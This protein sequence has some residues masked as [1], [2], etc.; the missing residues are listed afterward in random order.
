MS[1]SLDNNVLANLVSTDAAHACLMAAVQQGEQASALA[2]LVDKRGVPR[3]ACSCP[4]RACPLQTLAGL[5]RRAVAAYLQSRDDYQ[6][7]NRT[8]RH[9]PTPTLQ[10]LT[11]PKA[12][13][14]P[15]DAVSVLHVTAP[16]LGCSTLA[17]AA[18]SVEVPVGAVGAYAR[19][20]LY[21][22]FQPAPASCSR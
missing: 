7:A 2:E 3:H 21:G 17:R 14:M 6:Q 18:V 11:L 15:P 1:A 16:A 10:Q 12:P 8:Q 19:D 13:V 4:R 5:P 20:K 9:V 22:R